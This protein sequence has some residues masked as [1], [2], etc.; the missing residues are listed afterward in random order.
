METAVIPGGTCD[1]WSG[2]KPWGTAAATPGNERPAM[3]FAWGRDEEKRCPGES[4]VY[5]AEPR[6][7]K[8]MSPW[9]NGLR[10]P[11]TW[12]KA[13]A[14][15]SIDF[16]ESVPGVPAGRRWPSVPVMLLASYSRRDKLSPSGQ[17]ALA[18]RPASTPKALY[19]TLSSRWN[20]KIRYFPK[21][22]AGFHLLHITTWPQHPR[23]HAR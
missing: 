20:Q 9:T 16:R 14:K 3:A 23:L 8:N 4:T 18:P 6:M 11:R 7:S 10:F 2:S 12:G 1:T 13:G 21:N 5:R 19:T 22:G 15:D 17:S